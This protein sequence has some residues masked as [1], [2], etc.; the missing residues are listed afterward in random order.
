MFYRWKVTA[1]TPRVTHLSR[2]RARRFRQSSAPRAP[3]LRKPI[4]ALARFEPKPGLLR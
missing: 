2:L 3:P 4:C 1:Q